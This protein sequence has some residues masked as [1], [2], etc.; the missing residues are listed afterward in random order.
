MRN[1][2][3]ILTGGTIGMRNVE[4][5]GVVPTHELEEFLHSFP[6]LAKVAKVD[7]L[8]WLD[9]PS[10]WMTPEKMFELAKLVEIK[11]A[12]Y[13]GIVIT[14]GT[15]TL[16]E[17]AY[18]LDLVITS[19]K[20][21]VF[22]AAMRNFNDLG[23]DGPRNI[24]GAVRVAS[25][26]AAADKGVL[27]VM[28]DEIHAAREVIKSDTSKVNTFISPGYGK[29]GM[30]DPDKIIFERSLST[31]ESFW[32]DSIDTN[33]DLIK[34][35]AGMDGRYLKASIEHNAKAVVIEAFGRGNVPKEIVPA[36]QEVLDAGILVI[37]VTR[38]MT[39]RVMS[40]YG[41]VGGGAKL[42][43]MG[44]LMGGDLKG[45]KARIKL[46]VLFGKYKDPELVRK[47]FKNSES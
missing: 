32:T 7:V 34:L 42:V 33:V 38:S 10:P 31:N 39:G 14:H 2:L 45:Q 35:A 6:Q 13:D 44:C 46:M 9:I 47:F 43:E 5:S 1:I 36:I 23:L 27:V 19:S 15:D 41:Y 25:T 28:N 21:I 20:P 12:D 3:I 16:E 40:E 11:S 4:N 30:V 37:I 29:L 24:I 17:T 18:L 26:Y 22:T 8:D